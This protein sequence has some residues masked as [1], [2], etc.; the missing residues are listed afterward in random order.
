MR[1]EVLVEIEV[2]GQYD[3]FCNEYCDYLDND[4]Q[5]YSR[6]TLFSIRLKEREDDLD[7][8]TCYRCSDCEKAQE[9][10]SQE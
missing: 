10:N 7:H 1:K 4:S 2:D 3:E 9:K 6:C 5:P 8:N